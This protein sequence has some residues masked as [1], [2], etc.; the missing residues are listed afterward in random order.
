MR[1]NSVSTPSVAVER[2]LGDTYSN[3]ETV[4]DNINAVIAVDGKLTDISAVVPHLDEIGSAYTASQLVE[5]L[6]VSATEGT[7]VDVEL[8]DGNIAF[9]IPKGSDGTNGTGIASA[10]AIGDS[11]SITLTDGSVTTLT[12]LKGATGPKGLT[13]TTGTG[14]DSVENISNQGLGGT[15]T[16]VLH[17]SGSAPDQFINV[18]NGN[19][20]TEFENVDVTTDSGYLNKFNAVMSDGSKV[21]IDIRNGY[22]GE[23]PAFKWSGTSLSVSADSGSTYSTGVDLLGPKGLVPNIEFTYDQT[24]GELAYEVV[25]YI[26]G[27]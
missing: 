22:D 20:I 5:N 9:K 12:N 25:G 8:V 15:S 11:L 21:P 3:V 16:W 7:T 1:R 2:E 6:T 27:P 26:E 17:M 23:S 4:A 18:K 14:I 10:V 13:G 19:T 24:T